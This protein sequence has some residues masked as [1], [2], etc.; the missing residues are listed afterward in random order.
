MRTLDLETLRADFDHS[1]A[2]PPRLSPARQTEF[3]FVNLE[4]T[5]RAI[6][7]EDVESVL[8]HPKLRSA[9]IIHPAGAGLFTHR[10]KVCVALSL[11]KLLGGEDECSRPVAVVCKG[12]GIAL[13]VTSLRH[14]EA[15]LERN[16]VR[17]DGQLFELLETDRLL[18][19]FE[20]RA[21]QASN[22]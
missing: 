12:T 8:R 18:E 3:L 14:A 4:G 13:L 16:L 22:Q 2:E 11:A 9:P 7:A 20:A 1:F 17:L 5:S 19:G 21:R 6:R 10:G 15:T